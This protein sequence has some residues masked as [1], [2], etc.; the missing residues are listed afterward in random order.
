MKNWSCLGEATNKREKVKKEGEG[1]K[2]NMVD[3]LSI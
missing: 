3:E 2:V 1:K